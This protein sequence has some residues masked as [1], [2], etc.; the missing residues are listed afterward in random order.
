[1][2]HL[3]NVTLL[4]VDCV[5][6]ETT[7]KALEYS[8]REIRF[9]AVKLLSSYQPANLTPD[10]QWT[11]I[12]PLDLEGYSRFMLHNLHEYVETPFCL[13]IQYDG[14]VINPGMWSD[15]FLN[16]DYIGAPWAKRHNKDRVGNGGFS[17]R[18]KKLLALTKELCF[19]GQPE[20]VI[21]CSVNRSYLISKGVRFAPVEVALKFSLEQHI[22]ECSNDLTKC[23]GF[24]GKWHFDQLR[25]LD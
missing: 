24:H 1:M 21:I 4:S 13:I 5:K 19:N 8:A 10:I 14:F 16:Y 25:L 18:S 3:D 15:E 17:L 2:K 12:S 22:D 23:L 9:G 6:A 11:R 20:D 7:V